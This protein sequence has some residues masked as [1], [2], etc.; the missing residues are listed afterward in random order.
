MLIK[1]RWAFFSQFEVKLPP[2]WSLVH[3]KSLVT[4]VTT[5]TLM[6]RNPLIHFC[7]SLFI[8]KGHSSTGVHI[9]SHWV[10]QE[11]TPDRSPVHTPSTHTL[12]SANLVHQLKKWDNYLVLH[13]RRR[14]HQMWWL[15]ITQSHYSTRV[16]PVAL[17][18]I[19]RPLWQ[20]FRT[21]NWRWSGTSKSLVL[22]HQQSEKCAI[23][24]NCTQSPRPSTLVSISRFQ[25]CNV[26]VFLGK[27]CP[28]FLDISNKHVLIWI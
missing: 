18:S 26:E 6:K 13:F 20:P 17:L 8:P 14:K 21:A 12:E 22:T 9:I 27:L 5:W 25:R 11:H 28:H 16:V 7:Q 24:T 15:L 23:K 10:S 3:R 2:C 1:T 19:H 4:S